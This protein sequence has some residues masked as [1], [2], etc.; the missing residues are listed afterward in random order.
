[1]IIHVLYEYLRKSCHLG[2]LVKQWEWH[3]IGYLAFIVKVPT[4]LQKIS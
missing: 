1:M 2:G 3:Y 4:C